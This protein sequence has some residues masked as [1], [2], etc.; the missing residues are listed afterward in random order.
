MQVQG[1]HS[2]GSFPRQAAHRC[3]LLHGDGALQAAI[4]ARA[5][6]A[7]LAAADLA[8][9]VGAARCGGGAEL[10][11]LFGSGAQA[12]PGLMRHGPDL[13][14]ASR[15]IPVALLASAFE[16]AEAA[17]FSAAGRYLAA[18]GCRTVTSSNRSGSSGM[19]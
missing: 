15:W 11:Q 17:V 12:P 9:A 6:T 8:P 13:P 3:R 1:T 19:P 18:R 4:K 16:A 14:A 10:Q 7:Q 2:H 5:P